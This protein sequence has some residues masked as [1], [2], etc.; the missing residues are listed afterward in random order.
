[1]IYTN[2]KIDLTKQTKAKFFIAKYTIEE[3][4]FDNNHKAN[5]KNTWFFGLNE[6]L[7]LV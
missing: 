6:L 1:M 2:Y 4:I 3:I 7:V 5:N